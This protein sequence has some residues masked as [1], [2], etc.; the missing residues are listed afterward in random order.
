MDF[1]VVEQ[2]KWHWICIVGEDLSEGE[3]INGERVEYLGI[4]M[5]YNHNKESYVENVLKSYQDDNTSMEYTG[6]K[7]KG[8]FKIWIMRFDAVVRSVIFYEV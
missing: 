3:D 5:R 6:K 4:W 2:R 7:V 1:G 8:D